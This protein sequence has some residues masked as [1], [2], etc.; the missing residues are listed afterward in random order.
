MTRNTALAAAATLALC[1]D[2]AMAQPAANRIVMEKFTFCDVDRNH[3]QPFSTFL[4]PKGWRADTRMQWTLASA[5]VPFAAW[6]R[7]SAPDQSAAVELFPMAQGALNISPAGVQGQM[8]QD[9]I[10]ALTELA[11]ATRPRARMMLLDKKAGRMETPATGGMG[12]HSAQTGAIRVEYEENG[13]TYVEEFAT[14]LNVFST[15]IGAGY[16]SRQWFLEFPRAIRATEAQFPEFLPIGQAICRS[17]K[18]TPEFRMAL[19]VASQM[20]VAVRRSD[21]E[22]T[23]LEGHMWREANQQMSAQWRQVSEQRWGSEQRIAEG[24]RDILGG[25]HRFVN[26]TGDEVIAPVTH[27]HL[28]ENG[29]GLYVLTKDASFR[30]GPE[31][32]G[33]WAQL[34]AKN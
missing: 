18:V 1:M 24:R 4:I 23:A 31:L 21:L 27:R 16:E 10:A 29:Q 11:R 14:T 28:W 15:S 25:V 22:L 17:N 3:S 5:T 8:P 2:S 26:G 7:F 13:K 30:P 32:P 19:Q 6:A 20:A 34:R 12:T 9:V 33:D